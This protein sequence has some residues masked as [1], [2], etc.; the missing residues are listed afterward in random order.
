MRRKFNGI[1]GGAKDAAH[2]GKAGPERSAGE[3]PA[4]PH[5][6][7]GAYAEIVV[8]KERKRRRVRVYIIK[9]KVG[10]AEVKDRIAEPC[11]W[12]RGLRRN[13]TETRVKRLS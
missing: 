13:G 7:F 6:Y 2:P 12:S 3:K 1:S 4:D 9:R 11:R 8:S 5:R 10:C